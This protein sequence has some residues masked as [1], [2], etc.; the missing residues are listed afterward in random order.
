MRLQ[1]LPY[2]TAER[3][4][5][6]EL[7][8]KFDHDYPS[9]TLIFQW[10]WADLRL[11]ICHMGQRRDRGC[12][13]CKRNSIKISLP[14][15]LYFNENEHFTRRKNNAFRQWKTSKNH[16]ISGQ[17]MENIVYLQFWT[18]TRA[19]FF[20][21]PTWPAIIKGQVGTQKNERYYRVQTHL[22]M[23]TKMKLE[24]DKYTSTCNCIFD[25]FTKLRGRGRTK[26]HQKNKTLSIFGAFTKL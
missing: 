14:K 1:D 19:R 10:K 3:Q 25:A 2:G 21:V 12:L 7:Q 26:S 5:G 8:N 22:W 17:S 11:Q 16:A 13:N 9:K 20:W 4:G 18:F 6:R 15:H 24:G 23:W